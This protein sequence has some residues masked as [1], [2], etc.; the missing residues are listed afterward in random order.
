MSQTMSWRGWS[1][2]LDVPGDVQFIDRELNRAQEVQS[3]FPPFS[4]SKTRRFLDV[5]E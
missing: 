5:I 3:S 2:V 4:Y 1:L